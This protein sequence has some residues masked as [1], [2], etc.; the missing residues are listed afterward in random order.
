MI[1]IWYQVF[2][3]P[4]NLCNHFELGYKKYDMCSNY[5]IL[6]Y[7]VDAMKTNYDFCGS[8]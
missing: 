4:R 8:S 6:Y 1:K 3:M 2:M 5:C 7:R